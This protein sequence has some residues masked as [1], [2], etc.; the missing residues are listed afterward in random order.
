MLTRFLRFLIFILNWSIFAV[1]VWLNIIL[2]SDNPSFALFNYTFNQRQLYFFNTLLFALFTYKERHCIKNE[3]K[4]F[5][6]WVK[7]L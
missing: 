5:V 1:I 3:I 6:H 7:T 4:R 2:L